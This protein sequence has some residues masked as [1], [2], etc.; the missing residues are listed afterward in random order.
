MV[1]E[2]RHQQLFPTTL[3]SMEK[4]QFSCQLFSYLKVLDEQTNIISQKKAIWSIN[5]HNFSLSSP[6]C[7]TI[8][9]H[10]IFGGN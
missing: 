5:D 7:F 4:S 3:F 10:S 6:E 1:Q 9:G 8:S 2:I